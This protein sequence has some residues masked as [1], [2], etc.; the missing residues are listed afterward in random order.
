MADRTQYN[1]A[2]NQ[3]RNSSNLSDL[4]YALTNYNLIK[5]QYINKEGIATDREPSFCSVAYA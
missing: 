2:L 5:I 4:Q 1:E 3:E